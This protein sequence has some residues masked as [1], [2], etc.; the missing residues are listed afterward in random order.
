MVADPVSDLLTRIHGEIAADSSGRVASY[1]PELGSADP[2]L[3][4]VA[5]ATLD[6]ALYEAGHVRHPFTIQSVSKPF[7]LALAIED[8]GLDVVLSAVGVEPTGD[9]FN[10]VTLEP[11]TGR[12]PN[13]MVN[14]G[15]IVTSNLVD[16][17][18]PKS[19]VDRIAEGL[20]AFAARPLDI[21]EQVLASELATADRNRAIAHLMR[22]MG[23]LD[24][25]VEPALAVYFAQ[26]SFQVTARDLAVMSATLA[27]GG[28]NPVSGEF[29]VDAQVVTHVLSV[30]LTCGLYD[31][32]GEWV[33]R[34]G[35]PAKSGVGG[36]IAA[37]LPGQFGI[38][39]YSPRLDHQ[40]NSVRGV[41][42]CEHLSEQLALHVMR[43]PATHSAPIHRR[44]DGTQI[45]SRRH[46]PRYERA[47]LADQ[48]AAIVTYELQG[49]VT[50]REAELIVRR[51]M[52][53]TP[54]WLILDGSR[55]IRLD[56]A[57]ERLLAGATRALAAA[58]VQTLLSGPW[59]Q[60]SLPFLAERFPSAADAVERCEDVL[61]AEACLPGALDD[62]P[63]AGNDLCQPLSATHLGVL[64]S[65]LETRR[66]QPGW[67]IG[68][69][70]PAPG[71]ALMFI[72]RGRVAI[73]QVQAAADPADP[74][75]TTRIAARSAGT[76]VG[77]LAVLTPDA[78]PT[79][80]R[81]ET[82][83]EVL[84]L[85]E[86]ALDRLTDDHPAVAAALLNATTQAIAAEYRWLAAENLAL[87]R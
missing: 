52:S 16:G 53:E 26:C 71:E 4:G 47:V 58:G 77:S 79:R 21:D 43:P 59:R 62:I 14:A 48:S 82:E 76:A 8:R 35:L 54:R 28:R 23:S 55:V 84:L 37:A 72:T 24:L 49:V 9:P 45:R 40:G 13:P 66:Y 83:V 38:G 44:L 56:R 75:V 85:T 46:R 5:L 36:G 30:M 70:P 6:G 1:I 69:E 17:Q 42:A 65:A 11:H 20:S 15:A 87:A 2:E 34:T 29:V 78:T 73:E 64:A 22:S 57:A 86:T 33:L 60:D 32:S 39:T 25:E 18:D 67:L 80:L 41:A 63:L 61:V 74:P 10:A 51:V 31:F 19:R 7:V 68:P 3:F 27:N 81:A 12:P 50:F